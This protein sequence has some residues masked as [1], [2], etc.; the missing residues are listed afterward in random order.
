MSDLIKNTT[1]ASFNADV[2][3]AKG[4][5]LVDFWAIWC[6]PCKAIAPLLADLA[7]EMEG[8][9]SIVKID[10]EENQ[11]IPAKFGIR[12]IPTLILF[13]DGQQIAIKVGAPSKGQLLSFLQNHDVQ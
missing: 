9:L 13:K 8:I 1:D 2:I 5:V 11:E 10:V 3:D 4:F 7:V 6:G 12:N